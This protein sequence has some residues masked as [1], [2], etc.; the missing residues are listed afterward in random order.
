M[1]VSM[2]IWNA[3]AIA[4]RAITSVSGPIRPFFSVAGIVFLD[5]PS[6]WSSHIHRGAPTRQVTCRVQS[7]LENWWLCFPTVP[8]AS[9]VVAECTCA[10][11]I[12]SS[13]TDDGS[14]D[15]NESGKPHSSIDVDL[16]DASHF[17]SAAF[18]CHFITHLSI[19]RVQWRSQELDS[20]GRK[21]VVVRDRLV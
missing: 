10:S 7:S 9:L 13:F 6:T 21:S 17:S 16:N 11:V 18:K 3:L 1:F 8:I 2:A 12:F 4:A 14:T 15:W 19:G 5:Q 20:E